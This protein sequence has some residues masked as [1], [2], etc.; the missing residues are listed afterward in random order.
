VRCNNKVLRRHN[1]Q[2]DR[3]IIVDEYLCEHSNIPLLLCAAV[4]LSILS[5]HRVQNRNTKN[6]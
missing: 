2:I 1:F 4:G 3:E 5:K 6:T